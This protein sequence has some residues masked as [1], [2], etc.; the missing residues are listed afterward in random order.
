MSGSDP[1]A[2]LAAGSYLLPALVW[3]I[4]ARSSWR[5]LL[6]KHPRSRFFRLLP[7]MTTIITTMYVFHGVFS[8]LPFDVQHHPGPLLV[9]AYTVSNLAHVA[10]GA[11]SLHLVHYLPLHEQPPSRR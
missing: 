11:V 4:I 3:A 1:Y 6:M 2:L 5:F 9:V 10:L 7:V 8:L